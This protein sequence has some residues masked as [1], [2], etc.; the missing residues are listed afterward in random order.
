MWDRE[1]N[2]VSYRFY[3]DGFINGTN[4]LQSFKNSIKKF[5]LQQL[6]QL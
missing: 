5:S 3:I 2:V 4:R 6:Q 1:E